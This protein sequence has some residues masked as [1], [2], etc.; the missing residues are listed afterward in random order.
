[1]RVDDFKFIAREESWYIKGTE[2]KLDEDHKFI[3]NGK[4]EDDMALFEGMTNE[5]YR[6]YEGELPRWDGEWCPF[7]EFDIYYKGHK[8]NHLTYKDLKTLDRK[9]KLMRV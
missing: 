5:S 3:W 7:D 2:C 8:V 1:M 6:G 4:I 9:N